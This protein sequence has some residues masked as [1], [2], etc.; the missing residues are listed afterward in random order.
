MT[1]SLEIQKKTCRKGMLW[2]V[3]G[4]FHFRRENIRFQFNQVVVTFRPEGWPMIMVNV[5][6]Y[7]KW[8]FWTECLVPEWKRTAAFLKCLQ[9]FCSKSRTGLWK[10]REKPYSSLEGETLLTLR[11]VAHPWASIFFKQKHQHISIFWGD[12]DKREIGR[13]QCLCPL[14]SSDSS[15]WQ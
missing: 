6:F 9:T 3:E 14:D 1:Y 12:G 4:N 13:S 5:S 2:D 11:I 7:W 15:P 10:V 8:N